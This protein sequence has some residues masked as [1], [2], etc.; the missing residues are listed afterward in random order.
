MLTVMFGATLGTLIFGP[1][2]S[3]ANK[4]IVYTLTGSLGTVWVAAMAYYH[5]SSRG[6][7]AKDVLLKDKK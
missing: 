1:E 3:E 6:S 5:G 4:A 2:V 7:A